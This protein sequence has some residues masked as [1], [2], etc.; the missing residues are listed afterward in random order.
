ML[1]LT[2]LTDLKTESFQTV[3]VGNCCF[4]EAISG[5]SYNSI[6]YKIGIKCQIILTG[7]CT[8]KCGIKQSAGQSSFNFFQL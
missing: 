4:R 6:Y 1:F 3:F 5:S 2:E 8:V 7:G